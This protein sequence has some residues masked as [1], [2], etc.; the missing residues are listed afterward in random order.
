MEIRNVDV[1]VIG[2]GSAGLNARREF[3]KAGGLM[4]QI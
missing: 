2:S 3:E 1:A 4:S